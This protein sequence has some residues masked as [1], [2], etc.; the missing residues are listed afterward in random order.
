MLKHSSIIC[1]V[2]K[3]DTSRHW[4]KHK[5]AEDEDGARM[6]GGEEGSLSHLS[7][8]LISRGRNGAE[9]PVRR[10]TLDPPARR[11]IE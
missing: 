7:G 4:I 10:T 11:T 1:N 2:T 8:G 3:I 6:G 9:Y 5:L